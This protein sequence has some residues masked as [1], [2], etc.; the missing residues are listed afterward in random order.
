MVLLLTQP[1]RVNCRD[2][3]VRAPF[4]IVPG[5]LP[6]LL[7]WV[8]TEDAAAPLH[9]LLHQ[10]GPLQLITLLVGGIVLTYSALKL[11]I[12]IPEQQRTGSFSAPLSSS[13][14]AATEAALDQTSRSKGL[15]AK[16]AHRLLTIWQSTNSSTKTAQALDASSDA[17]EIAMAGSYSIPKLLVWAIPILGFL[18][19]VIGIGSAVGQFDSFLSQADDIDVLKSGLVQV[20]GGLGTAFDTTFLALTVSLLVMLPLAFTERMEAR[21]LTRMD[22]TLRNAILQVLP[23]T[24]GESGGVDRGVLK[25]TIDK[26]L[27]DHLPNPEALVEPAKVYAERVASGVIEQLSPLKA[28]ADESTAAISD[29]RSEIQAQRESIRQALQ[30]GADQL[31]RSIQSLNPLLGELKAVAEH[32]RNLDHEL[33]QLESGAHLTATLK[34]LQTTLTHTCSALEAASKP[35]K[36]VLMESSSDAEA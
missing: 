2:L 24:S 3:D 13:D 21:L 30:D 23:E 4:W 28:M 15:L 10:R 32:S 33:Q 8:A 11:G 16:R 14:E 36:V 12:L 20:T 1:A 31:N 29:A 5:L 34:D 17:Y 19:T 6:G 9:A 27:R 35:R 25:A 26:S 7:I 22:L 18:G